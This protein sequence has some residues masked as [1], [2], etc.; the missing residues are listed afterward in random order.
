MGQ[1]ILVRHAKAEPP[2]SAA[3]DHDRPLTLAGRTSA[4]QL[5]RALVADGVHPERALV[6]SALRTQQTWKIMAPILND[7][8]AE[9]SEDLYETHVGGLQALLADIGSETA[10]VIVIGH[11]P[12]ISAAAAAFAGDGSDTA[13]LQRVSHGLPTGTAAVLDVDVPWAEL[14]PRSAR[15]V[16]IYSSQA[17]F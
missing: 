17:H 4:A 2:S 14:A 1:L 16:G 8:P 5:A 15:L 7:I 11:E 12:T 13:S 6:S 3:T 10:S 9:T